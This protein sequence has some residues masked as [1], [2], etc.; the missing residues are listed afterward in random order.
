LTSCELYN[1]RDFPQLFEIIFLTF[2]QQQVMARETLQ[3]VVIGAE[4]S[5][6][7]GTIINAQPS[8][9]QLQRGEQLINRDAAIIASANI[10]QD[11]DLKMVRKS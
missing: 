9:T 1:F 7:T 5:P 10:T 4:L 8:E 11:A 2:P 6:T 3:P